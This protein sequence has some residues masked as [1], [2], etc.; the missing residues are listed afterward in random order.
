M[1]RVE[2]ELALH[3]CTLEWSWERGGS[4]RTGAPEQSKV[5]ARHKRSLLLRQS[6]PV[7]RRG[8][9]TI[10]NSRPLLPDHRY[11]RPSSTSEKPP[12]IQSWFYCAERVSMWGRERRPNNAG[13]LMTLAKGVKNWGKWTKVKESERVRMAAGY[14]RKPGNQMGWLRHVLTLLSVLIFVSWNYE[15]FI[16]AWYDELKLWGYAYE[17]LIIA[18]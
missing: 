6:V 12:A 1:S 10:V 2:Q 9:I 11:C 4:R 8:M 17:D 5:G 7:R 14:G 15:D 18:W 16:I 3:S 13:D